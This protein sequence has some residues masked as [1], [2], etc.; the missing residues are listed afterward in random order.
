MFAAGL[1]DETV[2]LLQSGL[3]ENR[4][5]MQAIGYRQVVEHIDG[6]RDLPKTVELVKQKTRQYAKRQGTWFRNQLK[7]QWINVLENSTPE[8]IAE[9]II[10]R[11]K[12]GA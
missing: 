7:L 2:G 9:M 6:L 5:A 1:V 8:G 10:S 3:K 11:F 4:T 12:N